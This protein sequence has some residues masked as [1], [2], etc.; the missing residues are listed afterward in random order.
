MTKKRKILSQISVHLYCRIL[1]FQFSIRSEAI[2]VVL[3]FS[4]TKMPS[5][6]VDQRRRKPVLP[7]A[8]HANRG[9]IVFAG[10]LPSHVTTAPGH[11]LIPKILSDENSNA[12]LRRPASTP[13]GRR[14][15]HARGYG[16]GREGQDWGTGREGKGMR[17]ERGRGN[18]RQKR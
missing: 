17:G 18:G 5:L 12:T 8:M 9:N 13:Q 6:K 3:P 14:E 1:K 11:P 15:E 4:M 2:R 7:P 16:E 10:H